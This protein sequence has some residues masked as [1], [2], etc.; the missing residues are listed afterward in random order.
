[1]GIL[2]LNTDVA[3]VN[4]NRPV[5]KD[6]VAKV[7]QVARTDTASRVALVL[8]ADATILSV[9]RE[10]STASDAATTATVTITVANNGGTV[11]TKADDVKGSGA[12]TG[13]VGMSNL[14]N[15]EPRPLNGDLTVSVIYAET[16]TASTTGGPWNY[17]VTYVR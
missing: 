17:V 8:P 16:G 14:P 3:I 1:M 5:A 12:T 6:V 10:G 4:T 11:S 13:F 7:F 9:M 2:V 15:A